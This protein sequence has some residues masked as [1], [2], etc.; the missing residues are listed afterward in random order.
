MTIVSQPVTHGKTGLP[1]Q[2]YAFT[3]DTKWS[4]Y[5]DIQGDIFDHLFSILPEFKLKAF[6]EPSGSDLD[7]AFEKS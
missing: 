4:I 6:Q 1:I 5:E 3:N 2:L 7:I